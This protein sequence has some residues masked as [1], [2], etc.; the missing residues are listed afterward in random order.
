MAARS[1]GPTSP[2]RQ[3]RTIAWIPLKHVRSSISARRTAPVHPEGP[4]AEPLA[5]LRITFLSNS[6]STKSVLVDL[7][8]GIRKEKPEGAFTLILPEQ[9]NNPRNSG[10]LGIMRRRWKRSAQSGWV[11]GIMANLLAER[12]VH[13]R[14]ATPFPSSKDEA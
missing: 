10:L 11:G 3:S 1:E 14:R 6:G 2:F 8:Q 12:A 4:G 5:H 13:P 9:P 7:G